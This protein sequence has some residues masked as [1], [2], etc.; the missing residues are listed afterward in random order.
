M[1]TITEQKTFIKSGKYELD[2]LLQKIN[3][4]ILIKEFCIVGGGSAGTYCAVNLKDKGHSVVLIESTE[5]LGGNAKTYYD[6]Q[7]GTPVNTGVSVIADTDEAK[8]Y[9]DRLGVAYEPA[10]FSGGNTPITLDFDTGLPVNYTSP[11]PSTAIGQSL[12]ILGPYSGIEFGYDLPD[13]VPEDLYMPFG[14]FLVKYNLQN[15]AEI[16]QVGAQNANLFKNSTI[17]AVSTLGLATGVYYKPLY[18]ISSGD[19][20]E[21]YQKAQ[22]VLGNDVLLSAEILYTK[23]TSAPFNFMVISTP[24]GFKLI[25]FKKLI[26]AHQPLVS[27]L[28]YLDLDSTDEAILSKFNT[29]N[30]V[31][32]IIEATGVPENTRIL[33]RPVN[34]FYNLPNTPPCFFEF[35]PTPIPG[36]T[37]LKYYSDSNTE[38]TQ[39]SVQDAVVQLIDRINAN[40]S[41]QINLV[42]FTFYDN[43]FPQNT[44]VSQTDVANGFY[45]DFNNHQGYRDTYYI[46]ATTIG[47]N[48]AIIWRAAKQLLATFF[49]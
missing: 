4:Q 11:D 33:N 46:N 5:L 36:K 41:L 16:L 30:Y 15:I 8:E 13:P 43:H 23:R 26:I 22:G 17:Y 21:I 3:A 34:G 14:D 25:L 47:H 12:Q 37:D 7:T 6:P 40:S 27:Q 44:V 29:D 39:Q 19:I 49:P 28:S 42:G 9:L 2:T 32:N 20:Y 48:S 18:N 35:T 1:N 31:V 45:K 10:D 24:N 38:I